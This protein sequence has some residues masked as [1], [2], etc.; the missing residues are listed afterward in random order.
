MT[1]NSQKM[2][3]T[4]NSQKMDMFIIKK[5]LNRQTFQTIQYTEKNYKNEIKLKKTKQQS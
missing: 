5:N 4:V 2:D 3:M 1:V